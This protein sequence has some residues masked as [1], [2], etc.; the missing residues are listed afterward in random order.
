MIDSLRET[1]DVID[2]EILEKFR[3]L[4]EQ[5]EHIL[6][7]RMQR[8]A[9]LRDLYFILLYFKPSSIMYIY[10][11]SLFMM[12]II[13]III[14]VYVSW[15]FYFECFFIFGLFTTCNTIFSVGFIGLL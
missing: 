8:W 4:T 12:N 3:A 5:K 15:C 11:H 7:R 1:T 9:S 14:V 10:L 2:D 6:A 13:Y